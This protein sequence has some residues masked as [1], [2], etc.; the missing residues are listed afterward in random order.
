M[1]KKIALFILLT[2]CCS[3]TIKAQRKMDV[4][5][6]GLVAVKIDKGVFLSWRR[7]GEEYYDVAYN[8]YRDGTK[9]NTQPLIVTNFTDTGGTKN[10]SYA[11]KAVVRG[12]E[13]TASKAVTAW[14]GYKYELTTTSWSGYF[15]IPLARIYDNTGAD[16]TNT[17]IANDAE[18][19]DLDGDGEMTD[20]KPINSTEP[21]CGGLTPAPTW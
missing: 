12:V 5:S 6:R 3:L 10:N 18:V 17:Y 4:L 15:N 11:V 8:I 9:L 14:P 7:L 2:V 21:C 19:A 20:L 13:Q 16:I 1:A